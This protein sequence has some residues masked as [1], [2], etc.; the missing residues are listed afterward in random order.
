[1]LDSHDN[2]YLSLLIKCGSR[3]EYCAARTREEIVEVVSSNTVEE[4]ER[5][6]EQIQ[7][8]IASRT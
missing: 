4:M 5:N 6:V 7:G 3:I 1:M 2:Y 8:W